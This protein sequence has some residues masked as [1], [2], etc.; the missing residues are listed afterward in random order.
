M[1]CAAPVA[2]TGQ[3]PA[4]SLQLCPGRTCL[5]HWRLCGPA[6]QKLTS[7][8]AESFF[9]DPVSTRRKGIEDI[10]VDPFKNATIEGDLKKKEE[11]KRNCTIQLDVHHYD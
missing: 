2:H 1:P 3:D 11:K 7:S 6:S 8:I 5:H 9:L 10:H 4:I